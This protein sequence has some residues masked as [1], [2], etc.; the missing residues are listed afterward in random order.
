MARE[1]Y[2]DGSVYATVYLERIDPRSNCR[3]F[4]YL[5]VV[6]WSLADARPALIRRYGRIGGGCRTMQP[7]HFSRPEPALHLME[8]TIKRKLKRG[9]QEITREE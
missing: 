1:G 6:P 9:Y 3:R 5:A 7:L 4:Y 8:R 2:W